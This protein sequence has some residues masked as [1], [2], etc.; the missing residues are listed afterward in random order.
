MRC[1]AF[2]IPHNCRNTGESQDKAGERGS[3]RC[4]QYSENVLSTGAEAEAG[5]DGNIDSRRLQ[6]D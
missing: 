1:G 6:K 5:Q 3:E 2:Q 4:P